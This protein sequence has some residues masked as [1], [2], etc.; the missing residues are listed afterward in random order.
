[1]TATYDIQGAAHQSPLL[2]EEVTATGIVTAL[3][4]NGFY[5]QDPVG[6]GNIATSDGLFVFTGD[7]PTVSV[8]DG[9]EVS[10]TV[11]E[12]IP[13][14]ADSGNL[15]ITQLE[16]TN[17]NVTVESS[18]NAVPAPT[19]IPDDRTPPTATIDD[20]NLTSFDPETD[21]IDFYESL[22]GMRVQVN[23]AVAVS[24][25]SRFGEIAVL[26]GGGA[27]AALRTPGGGIV[28]RPDD[29]NPERI[30]IDD[31]LVSDPP[32]VTV[33]DRFDEPVTGVFSYSFGNYKLL[34][35]EPLPPVTPGGLT[36]ETTDLAGTPDQLT[37]ATYNVLNL[38]PGDPPETFQTLAAGIVNNLNSPDIIGLQE[39]QD[40]SGSNDDGI[41]AADQTYQTLIDAIAAAG[42]PTYEYRQ[43]DPENNQD[44][45]A[46]GSNIRVGFLFNRD[47]VSFVDRGNAGATDATQ[48]TTDAGGEAALSLS[49]GRIDPENPA[50][51]ENEATGFDGTRKSLAG[52]FIFNGEKVFVIVNHWKSK[53]GDDPLFGATQPPQQET[54]QQRTAQ[55]QVVKDFADEILA[56]DPDAN[57]VILGDFND[58]QFSQPLQTLA[59]DEFANLTLQLP[60]PDRYSFIFDGNSQALDHILVSNHLADSTQVDA[61]HLN[62]EFPNPASDHD[63]M[64]AGLTLSGPFTLQLLHASDQEAG[65]PALQ[66]AIAF[67]A[68]MDALEDDYDNTLKLASGDLFIAGPF[69]EASRGIYDSAADGEPAGAPGL[70]D[71]LIQNELGWDVASV[72]NH[73]FD[74]GDETFFN[75]LAPDA[76]IVNGSA[77]G[78]GIGE[79]GYPG[80]AFPYIANNLSY[81]NATLPEGLNVVENGGAPQPNSLTGSVVVDVNGENIGVLGAL[82]PYLPAIANNGDVE[83]LTGD[84][85][86]ASTPIAEQV[87]ALIEN[88]QPEV[89][90]LTDAGVNKILLM[91]HLQE[92]EIERALAQALADAGIPVD[93]LVGGGSHRVMADGTGVPPLREDETQQN[94]GQLLQPYP[95]A[96]TGD[97][98]V[99]YVNTG[100]NY[101]Y[102]GQLVADFDAGGNITRIGDDSGTFATDIAGVDR[103]Y[104]ENITDFEGVRAIADPE[105]V[106]IVDGV[107]NF[108]NAL[109]GNIFGQ[110]DVF[111]NGIRGD[112]RTQET[113]LGNL[114]ADAQDYYAEQYLE[115]YGDDLL[116]GFEAI[117][118]SFKNGGGIRDAI[119]QSFIAGGGGELVQVPPQANP[120]VGKEEGDVSQLD[121]SNSLRFDN[122][123]T[124]GKV[125]AGGLYEI[126][127]HMVSGVENV[128]GRFGQIGGFKFSFDPAGDP[129]TAE[130]PGDRIQNLVLTDEAGTLREIIVQNGELV[131]DPNREFSV[132]TLGFLAGGGDSYPE[133][134]FDQVQLGTFEEP[135]TLGRADLVSGSEQD[136]LAEYLA[137]FFN[138]ENG[139]DAFS[140]VD[141]PPS[142]DDRIQNL[143]FREDT[144]LEGIT[145]PEA[146]DTFT[147]QILHASDLE[148]GVDAIERAPNFAAIVEG[149]ENDTDNF[150]ASITLSAGDNY[151]PGPFFNAAGDADTFREGGIFN[152]FYNRFYDLPN[153]EIDDS[154]GGL[155]EGV[156]RVDISIMNAIGFDAS[157]FGNHEFDLGTGTIEDIIAPDYQD[158]GLGDDR[159]VG[160]QFPYLSA[161]LDF[162]EDGSLSGLFTDELLPTTDFQSGPPES[163]AAEEVPKIAPNAIIERGGDRIGVVGATTPLLNSISSPGDVSVNP[164][165]NDMA[166]LAEVLQ[167]SIDKLLAEGINKIV[168]VTHLQQIGLEEELLPQL[169]GVDVVIAGGSD[170]IL[171]D[172]TD[173]LR[174]GDEAEG[175]YPIVAENA[176]GDPA[177]IVSS[178]GEYSYVGR[179]V[180]E[181]DDDGKLILNNEEATDTEISG[182]FATTDETVSELWGDADPFAGGT[183]AAAV[184]SLTDAVTGVVEE[185]DSRVFG[186]TDV[187]LNGA[188]E[189]VRTEATNLGILTAEANLFVAKQYDS[190]VTISIKNGGGIRAPIGE[191]VNEGETTILQ[192]PED[193][194]VSQLSIENALR[195]NNNLSLLTLTADELLLVLEHAVAATGLGNTPGQ[196]PQI[197]GLSFSFD[198]T[199]EAI[200]FDDDGNVTQAGD[201]IR[202]VSLLDEA[203][204]VTEPLVVDGE[205]V[206]ESDRTF[207]I[208]TLGFLAG[209]GDS[210]PFP[211]LAEDVVDLR[212]LPV[213]EG[214]NDAASFAENGSEQDALA[215]YLAANFS[216]PETA[217]DLEDVPAEEDIV[218]Q[219][220]AVRED[221]VAPSRPLMSVAGTYETGIFDR[222]GAKINAY[223]AETEQLFV[224]NEADITLDVLDISDPNNPT[225]VEAIDLSDFGATVNGVDVFE[226]LIAVAVEPENTQEAGTVLFLNAAGEVQNSVQVGF[227]PDMITFTPDGGKLLVANEGEANAEYTVDP[228][229]SIS[230]ID[231]AG[232]VENASVTDVGFTAFNEQIDSLREAG[233]RIFG[234]DATVAE[235]LEPEYIAVTADGSTAYVTLQENNAIAAV[236]LEALEVTDIFPLGF[237]DH[238]AIGLDFSDRDGAFNIA[239]QD[240][241]FGMY[242]PD[243]MAAYEVD[244]ETYLVVANEGSG[245]E[246]DGFNE[247]V[248]VEDLTLDPEAFPDAETL[249]LPEN[250]GRLTVTNTLGDTDGDGDF[251]ELYAFGGRSFTIWK[252]TETGLEFVF[253]SGSELEE[254]TAGQF[255]DFFNSDNDENTFDTRSDNKGPEPEP[256]T[257]GT[258]GRKTY[259][260]VGLERIGGI[261]AYDISDPEN[262]EFVQ[263]INN[264]NFEGD[265]EAGTAGDLGPEGLTMI[266]DSLLAVSHE[267]SGSTT[268][269]ELNA[270]NSAPTLEEGGT[271]SLEPVSTEGENLGTLVSDLLAGFSDD[272]DGGAI[273][274]A[275]VGIDTANGVW[276]FSLDG[277]ESWTVFSTPSDASARLLSATA[278]VRFVASVGFSGTVSEGISFRAWDGSFGTA[279]GTANVTVNGS[280]TAFSSTVL[281]ASIR[282]ISADNNPPIIADIDK[283]IDEGATITFSLEDFTAA[284]ED[285][286]GDELSAIAITSLPENGTLE[287]D[288]VAVA[289]NQEIPRSAIGG[290]T[291]T[292][293]DNFGGEVSF[294]YAAIDGQD[295]SEEAAINITVNAVNTPPVVAEPIPG[296]VATTNFGFSLDIGENFA[297]PDGDELTYTASGLPF[298]IELDGET[299]AIFGA[300]VSAGTSTVT[301]TA[302]DG[303]FSIQTTFELV[304]NAFSLPEIPPLEGDDEGEPSVPGI[305]IEI[306]IRPPNPVENTVSG[307]EE[308]NDLLGSENNDDLFG[309]G[310]NDSLTGLQ[311]DDNLY[312]GLGFDLLFGRQG[313]DNL[314]GDD[315]GDTMFGGVGGLIPGDTASDDDFLDGGNGNDIIFGNRGNDTAIG[316]EGDDEIY[317][318][319]DDDLLSGENGNDFLAGDLGDDTIVGGNGRDR[320]LLVPNAGT[321]LIADFTDGTDLFILGNGLTFDQLAITQE[322]GTT[323]VKINSSDE[324]LATVPG[325]A[326]DDLTSEDFTLL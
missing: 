155:R 272:G 85:I 192:P 17:A 195:F 69:F 286:D 148:G 86:T 55:A 285:E 323:V 188:R 223:D 191:V 159:W 88:L 75:L 13:G 282:V 146:G 297:D 178:D 5:L 135:A 143:A 113:N 251:D 220:L 80:A 32:S 116:A 210:Y 296:Q 110:T 89:Q 218:I 301:V 187:F 133:V 305:D 157:A 38:D 184:R 321:D 299:G 31:E 315:E 312:G 52:E 174:P 111:L 152:E 58:F 181:F 289:V 205:L 242:Q 81:D 279:G 37:V 98:T 311:G 102:L 70:A 35:P 249:Q 222:A 161:N 87:A 206:V 150:D 265:P 314:Y 165:G 180:V 14:G 234:P 233:V 276:E 23:E 214:G 244:G 186:F 224:V 230:V 100:A 169:S 149:L 256:L 140:R 121:I 308:N 29:F 243:E 303:E 54:V 104:D 318:G 153:T 293:D 21:G 26:A 41:V 119:G 125:T 53:G 147:L 12:F 43:I 27:N 128:S 48:V 103:L 204:N 252:P 179:L 151:I 196:F 213:P 225:F 201:R 170:T 306:P 241:L 56:A 211:F 295:T 6:D 207:R 49:P 84:D 250:L 145:P 217:F 203:G 209:G 71:I 131:G 278:R 226:G 268:L 260:F 46:P 127:E 94:N 254:I 132:V 317:G 247:E 62:A 284:F 185:K 193:G 124:L 238:G 39:I 326:V 144:V 60:E 96:F 239:T 106:A 200:A 216:T 309:L 2:G 126:A 287:L 9:V 139:Q 117:D 129:R 319:R 263:Y 208:V 137:A 50:F 79:G 182:I 215:E 61:V 42:G 228:E 72:G 20:D 67:S 18:G 82:T 142:G 271:P 248:R 300:P 240:N 92:A 25:T 307:N 162:S 51:A 264:R 63:P 4:G 257:V 219:N 108:V 15:S 177:V 302:S 158:A 99:Y 298:G 57:V 19:V 91:T 64:V 112:V 130:Q 304:V 136:A 313:D 164:T 237:K 171:A 154:Y 167:P 118:I 8:G 122:D 197:A 324:V 7:P 316:G 294:N 277:G 68:V 28:I 189:S 227:L 10:G 258:V 78:R 36:P 83:M 266:D 114:A 175:V 235:D 229:G 280:S 273:G 107:G 198:P 160:S 11:G 74:A 45:G 269:I 310:G 281:A 292:P 77:G 24:P 34:N 163:L 322:E 325:V 194:A 141:T 97:N 246:S 166:A 320:F 101:R 3:A 262:P 202:S 73:E 115:T 66:D 291:F 109:D 44:G 199:G 65:I 183:K 22:E 190:D 290:L 253:D 120:N 173:P 59:G 93:I 105:V 47:R 236:D 95:Q 30:I 138:V 212:E 40:N 221:P 156:G 172:D 231:L 1:M 274:I 168:L 261:M 16:A 245:R 76:D 255:S 288:G 90:A 275:V 270:L 33:G 259:A 232:G 123:L 176:D 134:I 267:V 283:E